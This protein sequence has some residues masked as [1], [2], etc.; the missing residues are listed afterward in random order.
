VTFSVLTC[1]QRS[2]AWFQARAGLLTA[3]GAAAMLSGP[4]KS[5]EHKGEETAGKAELR[6]RIA[7]EQLRGEPLDDDSF[8][9]DY[10]RRGR[11]R[12]AAA[13]DAYEAA[14]G[15]IVERVGFCRHVTLPVGCSPDG[16]VADG[17]GGYVGGVEAKSP[18]FTT[19]FEYLRKGKVPSEYQHQIWHS[20]F[21]TGL[22][23]WD[24]VSYCPEFEGP[25]RLFRVRVLR[26]EQVLD[27]Y[28]L[29]FSL[30]WTEVEQVMDTL[31]ALSAPEMTRGQETE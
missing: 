12:E 21:V 30:F 8:E 22:E 29:A 7:L 26:D 19:H 9:S 10:M 2:S 20:L 4:K 14:S 15:E 25:A 18:K 28:A 17:L 11:D 13:L 6:L 23:W 16:L 27:S 1:E 31:R 5:G 3:T 24:F